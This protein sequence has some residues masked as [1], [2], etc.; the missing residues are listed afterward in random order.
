MSK[1]FAVQHIDVAKMPGVTL[2]QLECLRQL[3]H[4]KSLR[5]LV[6]EAIDLLYQ[7]YTSEADYEVRA[8]ASKE[9]DKMFRKH[10]GE[11]E[12]DPLL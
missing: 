8:A 4:W 1:S 6:L 9:L 10:F 2:T 5:Q 3:D 11:L 7:K 12:N